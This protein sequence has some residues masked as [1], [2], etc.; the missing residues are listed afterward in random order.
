MRERGDFFASMFIV[1]AAG[2]LVS[3]FLVGFT[4]N[5]VAQSLSHK[6]RRETLDN[7]LRQDLQFFDRP[8]NSVGAL[9]SRVDSNP[10][11]VL[12]LMGF[13]VGLIFIAVLN[14][15]V[16]SILAIAHSWKLGLVVVCGGLPPLLAAGY[17]KI[18]YDVKLDNEI[19][20]KN[21][22][23]A[24]IASEAISAIRTVSS[25]AIEELV[26]DK[27]TGQLDQAVSGSLKPVMRVMVWFALTQAIEFWFMALGFWYGRWPL[28]SFPQP[29][30]LG[31]RY[32]CRLLSFDDVS[33]YDFFIAFMSVFFSGQATS[34]MF[35]FST[36]MTKGK[37]AANYIFWLDELQPTVRETPENR[38]FAPKS[39]APIELEHVR[40]SYP[41]RL[42]AP[43]LRGINL[44]VRRVPTTAHIRHRAAMF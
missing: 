27:Y 4:T 30:T 21:A 40:F 22:S 44:E 28:A 15:T 12:E 25:L 19:S 2:C 26:L 10:Q 42:D 18:R 8:E 43:V 31:I 16:C 41:L 5:T 23:S 39:G 9:V 14:V 7:M 38:D 37:T 20:K 33:M 13:N 36:S 1:L 17:L 34:Q 24:S 32:G 3:Y 35:Q 6:Y 11:S 29:L